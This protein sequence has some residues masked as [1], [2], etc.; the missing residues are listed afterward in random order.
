MTAKLVFTIVCVLACATSGL[1]QFFN[2][3]HFPAV[4][5]PLFPGVNPLNFANFR[6]HDFRE[7][8][9]AVAG[10]SLVDPFSSVH[11]NRQFN[12]VVPIIPQPLPGFAPGPVFFG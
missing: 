1:G 12:R 8:P 10:Y 11:V 5:G 9:F 2:G 6:Q 7:G 4:R 3:G